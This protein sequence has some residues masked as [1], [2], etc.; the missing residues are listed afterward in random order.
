MIR[1]ES[2]NHESLKTNVWYEARVAELEAELHRLDMEIFESG[3]RDPFYEW[4]GD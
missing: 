4:S 2:I 3:I 1:P